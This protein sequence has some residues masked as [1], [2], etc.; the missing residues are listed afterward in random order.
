[1]EECS[2]CFDFSSRNEATAA[3]ELASKSAW[4]A[5]L[6]LDKTVEKALMNEWF[7]VNFINILR[8]HFSYKILAPKI[9]KP[10]VD[11]LPKRIT[12]YEKC[13]RRTLMK[14]TPVL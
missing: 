4:S 14:L 9:T 11:K 10:K 1:M 6:D 3:L 8:K 7:A 13:A 5:A 12:T 2:K